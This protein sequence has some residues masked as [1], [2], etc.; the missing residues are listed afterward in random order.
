MVLGKDKLNTLEV[1]ISKT[2]VDSYVSHEE[3]VSVN[4]VLREYYEMKAK[5]KSWNFCR[6]HYIKIM[7]TYCISCKKY[8]ANE[9]SRVKKK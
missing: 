3:F 8:T 5:R 9:N 6:I 2:L 7:E 4:D 1:L